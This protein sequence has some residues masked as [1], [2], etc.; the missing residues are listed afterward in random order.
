L[1][2]TT[3]AHLLVASWTGDGSR[4]VFD[5]NC[6]I[7]AVDRDGSNLETIIGTWPGSNYCYNDSPDSNPVDGR[8]AWEN[9]KY[10]LGWPKPAGRI[11]AG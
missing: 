6:Y 5:H 8:I 11:P 9:E 2:Y 3:S 7:Y 1:V 4:L 10:G